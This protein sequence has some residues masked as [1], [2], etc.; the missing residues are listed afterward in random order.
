MNYKARVLKER[1][2]LGIKLSK[3][4]DFMHSEEYYTEL[5]DIN[6]GLLMVQLVAMDNYLDVLDRR[7]E[8]ME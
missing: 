1:V 6:K 8:L 4:K 2:G 5:D 3:L 7:L